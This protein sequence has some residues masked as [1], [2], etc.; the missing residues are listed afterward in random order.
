MMMPPKGANADL[1][2]DAVK[3]AVDYMMANSQ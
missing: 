1:S 2:D 3:A